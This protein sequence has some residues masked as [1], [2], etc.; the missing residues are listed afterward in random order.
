MRKKEIERTKQ[1]LKRDKLMLPDNYKALLI[2]DINKLLSHYMQLSPSGA[3]IRINIPDEGGYEIGI[4]C[5]AE[6][7]KDVPTVLSPLE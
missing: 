5:Y 3:K 4:C 6:R 1:I 7:L 2:S